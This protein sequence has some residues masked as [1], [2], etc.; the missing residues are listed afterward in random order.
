MKKTNKRTTLRTINECVW[1]SSDTEAHVKYS[2]FSPSGD[3]ESS[4]KAQLA[5]E[6]KMELE[7]LIHIIWFWSRAESFSHSVSI[8]RLSYYSLDS[9]QTLHESQSPSGDVSVR[10]WWKWEFPWK[11]WHK[12]YLLDLKWI[13]F[14]TR[15]TFPVK[16]VLWGSG[17]QRACGLPDGPLGP[18]WGP[19]TCSV[20]V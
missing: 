6:L 13:R 15:K 10:L 20:Q 11:I 19:I 12:H 9:T 14:Y 1:M 7:I 8:Q 16:T 5:L 4:H 3:S 2:W 17:F 18:S